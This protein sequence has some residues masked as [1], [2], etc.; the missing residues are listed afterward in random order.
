MFLRRERRSLKRKLR[1]A[2]WP[3]MGFARTLRYYRHRMGRLPGTP[4]AIASGFATGVAISF[5]PF[6]G[7][8]LLLG[9]VLCWALRMSMIGMVLGTVFGGNPWTFPLIWIGTYH[10]GGAM[11]GAEKGVTLP[12]DHLSFATLMKNPVEL[13]W[14]M[15]VGSLPFFILSWMI[16]FFAARRLLISYRKAGK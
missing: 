12:P 8:H 9:A 2:L 5:T 13:L 1:E 10:V 7:F 15:T 16:V 11:L 14:P 3:S 6:V 4:N